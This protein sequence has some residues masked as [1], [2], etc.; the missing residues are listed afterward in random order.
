LEE[1]FR[2]IRESLGIS[3]INGNTHAEPVQCKQPRL[4]HHVLTA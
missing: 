2:N 4:C 1:I 3:W